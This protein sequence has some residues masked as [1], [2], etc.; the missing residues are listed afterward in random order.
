MKILSY[1]KLISHP[2]KFL[3]EHLKNVAEFS[4]CSFSNLN[5]EDNELYS[6]I[7]FLIGL[8]HDFAKSTAYFQN[9]LLNNEKTEFTPHSFLSAVFT[10]YVVDNYLKENN[11]DYNL[12]LAII[13]YIVVLHHHGNIRNVPILE[14]YHDTKYNSKLVK[15]QIY[16]LVN[17]DDTLELFYKKHDIILDDFLNN[18]DEISEDISEGLFNFEDENN[19]DNYFGILLFY[20]VLLDA[21][22][23]DASESKFIKRE[24]IPSLIVDDYKKNHSFNLEGINKIREEAYVEVNENIL[25]LNLSNKIFSINLPTGIGKTLTGL[26]AVLK[27]KKRI[28]EEYHINPRIIYSLPFLSI[29]DQNEHVIRDIFDKNNISGSNYLLKHNYLAEMRYVNNND[30]EYDISNSKI[31]IEGWNSEFIITTFIQFFYSLIGNK[32][33]FLRKFHNITNS[34][35]L[36][37]EIQSIPYKY[38]GIINCILK[39]LTLEYNCWVILMTATQ[40]FIFKENEIISLV[41]NVEHYFNQFNRIYYNFQLENISLN[42]FSSELFN[43]ISNNLDKDIMVVLNTVKSSVELYNQVKEY[44]SD[45]HEITIDE[46]GICLVGDNI[47]LIYL[48]TNIL[49]FHRLNRINAIKDSK[50]KQNIVITTQLIEAGVDIDMDIVYRDFAPLDSIIQT[51]GRCNRSGKKDNGIVTVISLI[52]ENGKRYS[53]FVYQNLL[54]NTTREVLKSYSKISEKDFNLNASNQYF[55]LISK[56][57]FG[58]EELKQILKHLRFEEIPSKFKLIENSTQGIDVFVCINEEAQNIFKEY[59]RIVIELSSIEKKEDFLKIKNKF[60]QY[61]ISVDER[62]FGATNIFNDEIGVIYP[63]DLNFKYSLEVGFI[64]SDN[65]D[66]MIW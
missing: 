60:Y 29:I 55:E 56:R 19:F 47:N 65:E 38:W 43:V 34:I 17:K 13:S 8:S 54:L 2:D 23:M 53:D 42:E 16:D 44:L 39:K 46:N 15:N 59:K 49:P 26:S 20:S 6:D 66:P 63:E 51:A 45:F 30:E 61:V 48:S 32:N 33:S 41:D 21:D 14:E 4:K 7:A 5:F 35:I 24:F 9:Y 18:F 62:K 22:K 31:L 64:I 40:P 10:Y 58:D 28:Y 27:L 12:N 36:L 25:D 52:N 3:E 57:S 1:S 11:V 37:D 50:G